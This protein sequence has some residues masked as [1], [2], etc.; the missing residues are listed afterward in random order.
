MGGGERGKRGG[1]GGGEGRRR[2]GGERGER[3]GDKKE[4]LRWGDNKRNV[5]VF[6]EKEGTVGRGGKKWL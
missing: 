1:R 2:G 5:N 6:F 4:N 3:G